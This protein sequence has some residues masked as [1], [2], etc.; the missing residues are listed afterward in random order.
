M[1]YRHTQFGWILLAFAFGVMPILMMVL[2]DSR[3]VSLPFF[4]SGI[5]ALLFGTL[6]VT[7]DDKR[8]SW[9]FGIGLIRKSLPV[10][11][12]ASFRPV[13]N[14]W[15]Y[16]WGIRITPLGWLYN[17]SGLSAVALTLKDGRGVLIGTDEPDALQ[18]A[19]RQVVV[20]SGAAE[21]VLGKPPSR[22]TA[23]L[24]ILAI[25]AIVIPVVVWTFYAGSQPP[26]VTVSSEGFVVRGGFSQAAVQFTTIREVS[27]QDQIPRVVRKRNG[28]NAGNTL[29][30]YFTLDV[31]GDGKIFINRDVPPYVVVKT[32]DSFVIVNFKN[33][34]QT[35]ALAE[36]LRRHLAAR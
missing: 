35:R 3:T 22:R 36:E 6:T 25:N 18:N 14:R 23:V 27:L 30:G 34:Q 12:V 32:S 19:L 15:W 2:G 10:A 11:A 31:L 7:V 29:R 26:R 16:G 21:T 17:V 20:S 4:L 5:I 24:L 9:R 13:R 8:I 33:P 28:F 1:P